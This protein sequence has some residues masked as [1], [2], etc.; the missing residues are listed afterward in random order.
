MAIPWET[1]DAVETADGK[2]ALLRR[3][4][5]DFLLTLSG[6]VLM[7]SAA[8]RSEDELA[9][10]ACAGLG[11]ETKARVLVSGLGMGFTLRASLDAMG[12]RAKVI[13][14]ELNPII[15]TWCEGP[16]GALTKNAARHKRVRLVVGDVSDLIRDA[17]QGPP[18]GRFDAIVL[19]LYEGPQ[20]RVPRLHPLYGMEAIATTGRAL[21]PGG[22][23]AV[24]CEKPSADFER[25]LGAAGFA[26]EAKRSGHGGRVHLVYVARLR[27]S[28][29]PQLAPV[30]EPRRRRR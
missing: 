28:E 29:R 16:L 10:L 25:A 13:V 27:S 4:E 5:R 20:N 3:G 26:F 21:A 14:A 11:V 30:D 24:W 23:F 2:L 22:R 17:A 8:H 12:P 6:R 7:T 1:L 19:D 9:R 15:A 18:A